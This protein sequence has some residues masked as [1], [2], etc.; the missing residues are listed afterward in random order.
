MELMQRVTSIVRDPTRTARAL[1]SAAPVVAAVLSV[2]P[3]HAAASFSESWTRL[4]G[5][6]ADDDG[7]EVQVD[8]AGNVY[9][10]G[11]SEG[12]L[13]GFTNAGGKDVFLA[14]YDPQGNEIWTR[15]F[16]SGLDDESFGLAVDAAGTVY[17]AG[18]TTGALQG[19]ANAGSSDPADPNRRDAFLVKYDTDGN[20]LWAEQFGGL[21]NDGAW[22]VVLDDAGDVYLSGGLD[23]GTFTLPGLPRS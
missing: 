9:V 8:A 15:Q 6:G 20:R 3:L 2:C 5:T 21:G 16:G 13:P 18:S 19:Q 4:V 17:V 12:S 14:K 23:G 1:R 7:G 22:D 11:W 10:T